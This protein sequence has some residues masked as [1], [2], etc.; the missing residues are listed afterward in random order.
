MK[1]LIQNGGNSA[2]G[3]GGGESQGAPSVYIPDN[4]I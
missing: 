1:W 3:G 4:Y 2:H